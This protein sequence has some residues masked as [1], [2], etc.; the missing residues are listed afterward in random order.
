MPEIDATT[1]KAALYKS[2]YKPDT[3]LLYTYEAIT[4]EIDNLTRAMN[5]AQKAADELYG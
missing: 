4:E 5:R 3:T 1:A 2:I